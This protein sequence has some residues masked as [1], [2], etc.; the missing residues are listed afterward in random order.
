M[1]YLTAIVHIAGHII[2]ERF[3]FKIRRHNRKV[4]HLQGG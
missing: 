3:I 2:A 1:F 4:W